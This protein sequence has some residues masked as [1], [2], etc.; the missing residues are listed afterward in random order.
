MSL[1]IKLIF[2]VMV[3]NSMS[4]FL[5]MCMLGVHLYVFTRHTA[6]KVIEVPAMKIS[7]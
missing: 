7:C 2:M 4:F 1:E 3:V 6:T 5:F